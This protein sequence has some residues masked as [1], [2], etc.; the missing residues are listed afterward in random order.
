MQTQEERLSWL[1]DLLDRLGPGVALHVDLSVLR[2]VFSPPTGEPN[3]LAIEA[4]RTFAQER[5]CEFRFEIGAEQ[6]VFGRDFFK[7]AD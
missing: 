6:G 3:D 1:G 7:K 4:A 2:I 5:H